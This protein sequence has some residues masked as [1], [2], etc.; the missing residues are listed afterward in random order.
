MRSTSDWRLLDVKVWSKPST[1]ET[2]T[3][4]V[5]TIRGRWPVNRSNTFFLE[6][7]DQLFYHA[8]DEFHAAIISGRDPSSSAADGREALAIAH[9]CA[10]SALEGPT[11]SPEY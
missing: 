2:T 1:T 8:L 6:R 4:Y 5:V 9:A 7:Y 11:I 3:S 10:T